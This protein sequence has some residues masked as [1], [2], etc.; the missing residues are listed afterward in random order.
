MIKNL[1]LTAAFSICLCLDSC[2]TAQRDYTYLPNSNNMPVQST[3][4][5]AHQISLDRVSQPVSYYLL[6]IDY[7]SFSDWS[8]ITPQNLDNILTVRL[9]SQAG[10]FSRLDMQIGHIRIDQ[11]IQAAKLGGQVN[12]AEVGVH[13]WQVVH[14]KHFLANH[15]V[16]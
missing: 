4:N 7:S 16:M 1:L 3:S 11:S 15:Q 5:P 9:V 2:S 14:N 12:T 8:S 6:Q 13:K 10:N